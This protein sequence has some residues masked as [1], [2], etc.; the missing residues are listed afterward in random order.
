[1]RK[2]ICFAYYNNN[3]FLGWYSDSFG[4]ITKRSS[5]LYGYSESQLEIINKNFTSKVKRLKEEAMAVDYSTIELRVVECPIYDGPNPEFD[6]DVYDKAVQERKDLLIKF[7]AQSGIDYYLDSPSTQRSSLVKEFEKK[8]P[9]V[10]ANNWIHADY[11]K[12]QEWA[13]NEPTIFLKVLKPLE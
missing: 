7:L 6:K 13:S 11:D 8:H 2:C 1:M 3:Q 10:I 4:T 5:K 9:R 12:V